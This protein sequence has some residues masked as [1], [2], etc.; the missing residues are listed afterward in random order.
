V[1]DRSV[2]VRYRA[3]TSDLTSKSAAAG[4][5]VSS[6][7]SGAQSAGQ[8]LQQTTHNVGLGF[9]AL[10]GIAT[11][12]VGA[13]IG[14]FASF[15][16]QM[17]HIQAA[18][19]E[20]AAGM[21]ILTDA[22][23][24]AGQASQFSA[25]E[26]GQGVEELAKA[27]VATADIVGGA[28]KGSLDLAAAGGLA[29]ADS[30]TTM[31]T[32]MSVF[33]VEGTQASHVA[34][35]LAAGAGKAQGSVADMAMSL[36][37][38]ALVAHQVGLS[39]EDTTGALAEFANA[40]L[41]GSDA[42]TSFRTML[43]RLIN[44]SVEAK[45]IMEQLGI[46]VYDSQGNFAG[47]ESIAG[48][49]QTRLGGLDETTRNTALA[50]IFGSD[51]IR[52]ASV[53]YEDGAAGVEQWRTSVN[54]AGYAA[55]TARLMTDNLS[56]DL[57]RLGGAWE[58]TMIKIG[59]GSNGPL[60]SGVQQLTG[61]VDAIGNA[62]PALQTAGLAVGVLTAGVGLL[63]G[64]F[65]LLV[66]KIAATKIA[67]TELGIS[68]RTAGL[69]LG[70]IAAVLTIGA[71]VVGHWAQEQ[72]N[73]KQRADD[74]GASLDQ[75][76]GQI[77]SNTAAWAK[78]AVAAA[79]VG[80]A[81]KAL[82]IPM[83]VLTSAY[84]GNATA[85]DEVNAAL[86]RARSGQTKF[87]GGSMAAA[88]ATNQIKDLMAEGANAAADFADKNDLAGRA[89]QEAADKIRL[90]HTEIKGTGDAYLD[91][92]AAAQAAADAA[93]AAA[94]QSTEENE[95][96]RQ[97]VL[98]LI[99]AY[100]K[101]HDIN[102]SAPEAQGAYYQSLRDTSKAIGELTDAVDKDGHAIDT[103]NKSIKDIIDTYGAIP[104]IL[105]KAKTGFDVTTEAGY[106]LQKQFDDQ[107]NSAEDAATAAFDLATQQAGT[108]PTK[109]S[110]AYA[111]YK[112]SIDDARSSMSLQL[113]ALGFGKEAADGLATSLINMPDTVTTKVDVDTKAADQKL[114]AADTALDIYEQARTVKLF[115][116]ETEINDA[117]TR[118]DT[119]LD[120]YEAARTVK[121]FGDES[122][123]NNVENNQF[124]RLAD[125]ELPRTVKLNADPAPAEAGVKE[126]QAAIDGL[127]G[128]TVF[129]DLEWREIHL[130]QGP[131]M[132][133]GG[134]VPPRDGGSIRVLGEG[135]EGEYVVP[136]SKV[137][138]F[139]DQMSGY[140]SDSAVVKAAGA[141]PM[142]MPM[143]TGTDQSWAKVV[144]ELRK[145]QTPL[146]NSIVNYFPQTD[147]IRAVQVNA[148]QMEALS[149]MR[150]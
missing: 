44:P 99:D 110:A 72:T 113:Q 20:S 71:L 91:V 121:L 85:I 37:Q 57:E 33:N 144:D 108:D 118:Q 36:N 75:Q 41:I 117:L 80:D 30:A 24:A 55:E 101:L 6:A 25:R 98:D 111:T 70:G 58:T 10:G 34:D 92:P 137:G 129:M 133:E 94:G 43:L 128:K 127:H 21:G 123:A 16:Q 115:G 3:D 106:G 9:L 17:S 66:P 27:G 147:D 73:A 112:Q 23:L 45:S 67:L 83:D 38:S 15:D 141:P 103:S 90:Q 142:I 48:Q 74:F 146:V 47:L 49:L 8:A 39:V 119:A 32:A 104:G 138:R 109:L 14:T 95:T 100:D 56:G 63:G 4:A 35:L 42:G 76:T 126:A 5:S 120:I 26:A 51:A 86:D 64:A 7:F 13:A 125:F 124:D 2:T 130:P 65:L 28:L 148:D 82:G 68:A 29:V 31:A 87:T 18:T 77:T 88:Q 19:H 53:L 140:G 150:G 107:A 52:A 105:D 96:E 61:L 93:V 46:S 102:K 60:R 145:A 149:M 139:V 84:M 12:G 135:G 78:N 11:A 69:A 89:A 122:A 134:Y 50:T 143:Q 132:A 1:A 116:D 114:A 40:G 97:G 131:G 136:Q 22:T 62:S 59:S 81:A 54:D 79:D